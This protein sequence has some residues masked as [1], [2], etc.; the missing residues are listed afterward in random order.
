MNPAMGYVT[1]ET[2]QIKTIVLSDQIQYNIIKKLVVERQ[3]FFLVLY[4]WN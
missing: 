1:A 2:A 3:L 4:V